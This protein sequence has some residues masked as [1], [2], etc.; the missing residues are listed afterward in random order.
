MGA[1]ADLRDIEPARIIFGPNP[2]LPMSSSIRRS[3]KA[4]FYI[5]SG[6]QLRVFE[7]LAYP[8]ILWSL[9]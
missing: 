9:R 2:A 5:E 6:V 1:G 8:D 4:R 7:H 3:M